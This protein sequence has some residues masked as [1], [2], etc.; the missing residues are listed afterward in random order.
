VMI[1]CAYDADTFRLVRTRSERCARLSDA[2]LTYR[3]APASGEGHPLQDLAY[4]YDIDGN[5]LT[6]V[7]RTPGCG[8]RDNPEALAVQQRDPDLA[9]LLGSGDALVRRFKYDPLGRLRSA[10]GRECTDAAVPRPWD[11][12][13]GCG[14]GSGRHGTADQDNA[15]MLTRLYR[16]RYMYDPAGNM[17]SLHHEAKGTW[18][19]H[20]GAAG[21]APAAWE[22]EWASHTE[23]L[24]WPDAPGNQ[25][26]HVGDDDPAAPQTHFYDACGNLER[27]HLDRHL[28]WDHANRLGLYRRQVAASGSAPADERWAEPSVCSHYLYDS[29]GQRVKKLV[30]LQGGALEV[31]VY[32][33][34][35]MERRTWT[36]PGGGTGLCTLLHVSDDR[37]RIATL[38]VGDRHPDDQG[39]AMQYRL[40]D[41]LDSGVLTVDAEGHWLNREEYT[42]Y[43]ETAFG[44][45]ARKRYR[46]TGKERDTESGLYY[47]GARYY[48]PWL[49]RWISCDPLQDP[50]TWNL[51]AY[52]ADSPIRLVDPDGADER[53]ADAYLQALYESKPFI[54][55][56]ASLRAKQYGPPELR[57][58]DAFQILT[59]HGTPQREQV[60][61]SKETVKDAQFTTMLSLS[62][63][64]G[65][66]AVELL[67][68]LAKPLGALGLIETGRSTTEAVIGEDLLTGEQL[69]T[70][71]RIERGIVGFIGIATI[72]VA[73]GNRKGAAPV[74]GSGSATQSQVGGF[75]REFPI[76]AKLAVEARWVGKGG[77]SNSLGY[78]RGVLFQVLRQKFP[79]LFPPGSKNPKVT[80]ELG[81]AFPEFEPY[82]GEPLVEHHLAHGG[83]AYPLPK[84]LHSPK[85]TTFRY[86]HGA[87]RNVGKMADSVMNAVPRQP[88]DGM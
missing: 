39:P 41:H 50:V 28:S 30:R 34:G 49:A 36:L 83:T 65:L 81:Q 76:R 82:V 46:F 22:A 19:R 15:P 86:L 70:R 78:K 27:Q 75:V 25:L 79:D 4:S 31:T 72:G 33:G 77:G 7:E 61:R 10:T 3:P 2:D 8:V 11:D 64:G 48:A 68:F 42:P 17:V 69:T 84:S 55:E 18:T 62:I 5:L 14:F 40:G 51:Y 66:A 44:G 52:A 85:S 32:A 58:P 16:Q 1:R 26:T 74:H 47:H 87:T 12:A 56:Q 53:E 6:L 60:M 54:K 45:F 43:G 63:F 71:G 24:P 88:G 37:R 13:R 29:T 59:T 20:F 73:A 38:R 21:R 57:R 35:N 23:A 80:P 9:V 67:P